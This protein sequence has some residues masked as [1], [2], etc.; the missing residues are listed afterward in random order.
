MNAVKTGEWN[1]DVSNNLEL[2][3]YNSR[4]TQIT[5]EQACL[6]WGYRV[7]ILAKFQNKILSE[8]HLCHMISSS[9]KCLERSYV[10]WQGKD[11]EIENINQNCDNCLKVRQNPPKSIHLLGNGQKSHELDCIEIFLDHYKINII[12]S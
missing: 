12:L 3:S 9:M 6:L 2:K 5:M 11:K 7:I 4:K 10:W 8:L 1:S